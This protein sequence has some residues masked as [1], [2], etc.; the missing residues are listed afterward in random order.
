LGLLTEIGTGPVG[1]DSAIF[2]YFIERDSRYLAIVK[3]VF[4]AIDEGRLEAVTSSLSL[5]ETLVAPLR[6]GN[7]VVAR[8]YEQFLTRSRG[9]EMIPIDDALLRAAA[10]LRA[11]HRLK[12]PDALQATAALTGGCSALITNDHRIP[13]LP[14]LRVLQLEDYSEP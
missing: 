8:Q 14:G 13:S 6:S 12:T 3:P 7:E 11:A 2:I 9:L 4:A 5:L 10:H 1:L